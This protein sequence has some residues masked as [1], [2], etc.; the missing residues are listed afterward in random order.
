MRCMR[1]W[2]QEQID[3]LI[4]LYPD[5]DYASDLEPIVGKS[6]RSIYVKAR[7]LGLKRNIN[8]GNEN[9]ATAG[10]ANRFKKGLVPF[11]KGAKMSQ[12]LKAKVAHTFFKEGHLPHNTKPVGYRTID[13][14]GYHK[15]KTDRGMEYVHRKLWEDVNGAIPADCIVIFKDG[16]RNNCEDINNL[17]LIHRGENMARNSIAKYPT[18]VRKT[19]NLISKLNRTIKNGNTKTD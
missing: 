18:E 17:M 8:K 14:D 16:N 11:N 1:L 3:N 15:V 2:T 5:A 19:I 13:T 12:E 10:V 7:A 6:L 9:L 4:K